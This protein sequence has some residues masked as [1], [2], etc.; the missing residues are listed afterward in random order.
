MIG[1][2]NF[3]TVGQCLNLSGDQIS[4]ISG[5]FPGYFAASYGRAFRMFRTFRLLLNL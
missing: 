1:Q 3:H 4:S 5:V 2:R